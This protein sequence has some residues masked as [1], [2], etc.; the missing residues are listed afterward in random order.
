MVIIAIAG[1]FAA[2]VSESM[3]KIEAH[4]KLHD[5]RASA[6]IATKLTTQSPA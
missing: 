2:V 1:A 3:L 6:R 5:S 4:G